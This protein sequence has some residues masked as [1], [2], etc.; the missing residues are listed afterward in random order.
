AE[1]CR[2]AWGWRKRMG[3]PPTTTTTAVAVTMTPA[4]LRT[5]GGWR[6]RREVRRSIRFGRGTRAGRLNAPSPRLR[7]R[8]PELWAF[9]GGAA[10]SDIRAKRA[11]PDPTRRAGR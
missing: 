10:V 7:V 11:S 5:D 9:A 3:L 1:C 8:R 2:R 6:R 4:A